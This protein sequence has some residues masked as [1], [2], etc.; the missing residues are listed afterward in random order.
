MKQ[1]KFGKSKFS[2]KGFYIA[3][4]LSLVAVGTATT[5]A[6]SKT[7]GDLNNSLE[8]PSS[9]ISYSDVAQDANEPK[10]DVPM[11][12]SEAPKPSSQ[13]EV[14]E[15]P[16]ASSETAVS[17]KAAT[18]FAMPLSGEI[19]KEFS[20]GELVKSE[21][22]GDWRTHD[23]IDIKGEPSTPVKTCAD[24]T[25]SEIKTDPLLGV[26]ITIDHG[27]GY[28]SIYCGLNETVQVKA[29]QTVAIG[30]VI[31]SIGT[32]NQLEISEPSHLHFGMKKDDKWIDPF[33]VIQQ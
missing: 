10:D 4:A 33:S 28:T 14:S 1:L 16:S 9:Q 7:I 13:T 22:M 3:L 30:D 8:A 27:N 2:G 11:A 20:N 29:D 21:T 12:S 5:V 23:G 32:T 18:T 17:S 15:T 6:V 19:T 25:V 24:G 26:C 31:G